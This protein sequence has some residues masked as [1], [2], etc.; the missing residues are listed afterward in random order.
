MQP[1]NANW[2][3]RLLV[4]EGEARAVSSPDTWPIHP[5]VH[6]MVIG[7]YHDDEID[8]SPFVTLELAA[9][10]ADSAE[11]LAQG[12][13]STACSP[14]GSSKKRFPVVWVAPLRDDSA[15]SHRFLE[16]ATDLV[17]SEQDELAVVAAQMHFELQL[18]LLLERA[19]DRADGRWAKRLLKNRRAAM[20]ANDVSIATVELLLGADV[21]QSQ[22]WPDFR[23][24]LQRRN[25][26]VHEGVSVA[27]KE[28]VASVQ[29]VQ[30]LWAALAQSERPST[31][32]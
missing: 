3:V 29:V 16:E 11:Q 12:L 4:D 26:V 9:T 5:S 31:L 14:S 7:G 32:F 6:R 2:S 20:P 10:D 27:K 8:S 19:A 30:A 17:R 18:S 28:A 25:A 15:N 21:T 22:H 23:A 1:A 13:V 24:H